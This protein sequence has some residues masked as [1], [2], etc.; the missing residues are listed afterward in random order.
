[1][2]IAEQ[3]KTGNAKLAALT[4]YIGKTFSGKSAFSQVEAVSK[5][6]LIRDFEHAARTQV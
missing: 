4:E 5:T 1:M 3:V 6:E 2:K